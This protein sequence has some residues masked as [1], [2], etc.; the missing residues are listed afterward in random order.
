MRN[1]PLSSADSGRTVDS[2]L[3]VP[4]GTRVESGSTRT[5]EVRSLMGRFRQA[6]APLLVIVAAACGGQVDHDSGAHKD[7]VAQTATDSSGSTN[8]NEGV[9]DAM[10][11]MQDRHFHT[12]FAG[13]KASIQASNPEAF[14]LKAFATDS[15]NEESESL[16]EVDLQA[17]KFSVEKDFTPEELEALPPRIYWK[18]EKAD[19]EQIK[20]VNDP[21][22]VGPGSIYG[23]VSSPTLNIEK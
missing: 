9:A 8:S 12:A 6:L 14:V 21:N 5:S 17:G 19:G 11:A 10:E 13:N 3:T 20:I 18:A 2:G 23:N 1:S 15:I 22:E 7:A 4:V 16:F